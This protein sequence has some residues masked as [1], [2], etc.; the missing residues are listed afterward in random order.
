[1]CDAGWLTESPSGA[2]VECGLVSILETLNNVECTVCDKNNPPSQY[3]STGC[4]TDC[5]VLFCNNAIVMEDTSL[6]SC[7]YEPT[8]SHRLYC[9]CNSGYTIQGGNIYY[10]DNPTGMCDSESSG[11]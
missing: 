5:P 11:E 1:M 8:G 7:Y 6:G 2:T 10:E 3:A 9:K 4:P